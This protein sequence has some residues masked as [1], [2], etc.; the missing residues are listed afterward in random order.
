[1]A[2]MVCR[3]KI[4]DGWVNAKSRPAAG[5]EVL[6]NGK[7]GKV[8][9]SG[10]W[11]K[12]TNS[13][14]SVNGWI[15]GKV[16]IRANDRSKLKGRITGPKCFHNNEDS[17]PEEKRQVRRTPIKKT[18]CSSDKSEADTPGGPKEEESSDGEDCSNSHLTRANFKGEERDGSAYLVGTVT[19]K[20][21]TRRVYESDKGKLY[22]LNESGNKGYCSKGSKKFKDVNFFRY[23]DAEEKTSISDPD[24]YLKADANCFIEKTMLQLRNAIDS[25]SDEQMLT[26][27]LVLTSF[28]GNETTDQ[29][30]T[31]LH[32]I[33]G[34]N[35]SQ[36][37]KA[38]NNITMDI[39][40]NTIKRARD[41]ERDDLFAKD[42]VYKDFEF[43]NF[44]G[45]RQSN[46]YDPENDFYGPGQGNEGATPGNEWKELYSLA[47]RTAPVCLFFFSHRS[48]ASKNCQLEINN[49]IKMRKNAKD[50]KT[51]LQYRGMIIALHKEGSHE[52]EFA[53]QSVMYNQILDL[54][55]HEDGYFDT[56]FEHHSGATNPTND[57][58]KK[59][60]IKELIKMKENGELVAHLTPREYTKEVIRILEGF[61][62]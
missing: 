58:E 8:F 3:P 23:L 52:P 27:P 4:Q 43:L 12:I 1:M 32:C 31:D 29:Y 61:G 50:A 9:Y 25:D 39:I 53:R 34:A 54:K 19:I 35:L 5:T 48:V 2:S 30:N 20:D 22:Y 16:K 26:P 40:D 41:N 56:Y 37:A 6:I 46:I 33:K 13:D 11:N 55:N 7:I 62:Y 38:K 47:Q 10:S 45:F 44:I 28:G 18:N 60:L 49:Y 21:D 51:D 15:D 59:R 14:A 57:Q 24:G 36:H 42:E 17:Q